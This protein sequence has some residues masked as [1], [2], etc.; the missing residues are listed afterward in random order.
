MNMKVEQL[1]AKI[2]GDPLTEAF[3]Q[4]EK[5]KQPS[6]DKTKA[7][8]PPSNWSGGT[9]E[10]F[11]AKAYVADPQRPLALYIHVPFC[12]HRCT[13]CPF[14]INKTYSGFSAHYADLLSKEIEITASI[15]QDVIGQRSVQTI[16]FGG[17]TP[18]DMEA[19]DLAKIIEQLHRTFVIDA[20]AEVTVEGRIRGFA[21]D[22]AKR[23]VQAGAN[24][25]SIG[26]QTTDT[27]LR[28]KLS[29][30][31]SKEEIATTLNA[32]CESGASVVVDVMY[33]LPGQTPEMV[34]E[35]IRFLSEETG[36]HGMDLYELRVFPDSPLDLAIK[37]GKMPEQPGFMSQA[38]M[39][40][41]A[42]DKLI[43]Y[44]FENFSAKHWRRNVCE[45]SI[46]NTLAKNQTD[47]IPFGSG[48]GGR[49]GAISLGNSSNIAEY[50]EMVQSGVKPLK[51]IMNS[52]LR[53]APQGFAHDLDVHLE[54]LTLPA[55]NKWPNQLLPEA[56][57]LIEQWQQAG[58]VRLLSEN[59]EI[60]LTCA[61]TFWSVRIRKLLLDF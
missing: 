30:Q 9:F 31:S 5:V 27:V 13:F 12:H 8:M 55:L 33:A 57:T 29:R 18:S 14:Y 16:Y 36:I 60:Q 26:V 11:G 20:N 50:E 32:L 10:E 34:V 7:V 22:K 19:E 42:Y 51:R 38:K 21:A 28:K 41:A 49:L 23:W 48:A 47:M 3:E 24:R 59:D 15:L 43:S 1:F 56:K 2:G 54:K 17:G 39:F 58:L 46:Y 40:G 37:K 35:D 44:G 53:N 25:F 6:V 4:E 52:P 45:R 61:G